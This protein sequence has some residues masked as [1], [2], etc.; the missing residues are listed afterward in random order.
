MKNFLQNM[1]VL[2]IFLN[3]TL[4]TRQAG[5]RVILHKTAIPQKYNIDNSSYELHQSTSSTPSR[6]DPLLENTLDTD[7]EIDLNVLK[8]TL[9]Y[10]NRSPETLTFYFSQ[11]NSNNTLEEEI[12]LRTP[13][14]A[15]NKTSTTPNL[16]PSSRLFI[17]EIIN[18]PTPKK[19]QNSQPIS[20]SSNDNPDKIIVETPI[21]IKMRNVIEIKKKKIKL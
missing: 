13:K 14:N 9:T 20:F 6:T 18:M 19:C 12:T 3:V 16:S 10:L 11:T 5:N 7:D 4:D 1:F 8:P 2:T 21:K 15:K 17:Q